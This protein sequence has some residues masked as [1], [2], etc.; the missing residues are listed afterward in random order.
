MLEEDLKRGLRRKGH[1]QQTAAHARNAHRL[2]SPKP[3]A[4]LVYG[5]GGEEIEKADQTSRNTLAMELR[6]DR[7]SKRSGYVD[8]GVDKESGGDEGG[9]FRAG[10]SKVTVR[11][12]KREGRESKKQEE[13]KPKET[14]RVVVSR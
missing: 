5:E 7:G 6:G 10:R 14:T 1:T 11:N 4:K 2:S 3:R 13:K 9:L 12:K 8:Q